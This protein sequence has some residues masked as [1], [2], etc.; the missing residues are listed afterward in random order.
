M[1]HRLV[2]TSTMTEFASKNV[3]QWW[4]TT[5]Q[6]IHGKWIPKGSMLMGPLVSKY[7]RTICSK[8][9]VHVSAPVHLTRRT[10]IVVNVFHVMA[11]VPR[12]VR[13]WKLFTL[14]TSTLSRSVPSLRDR[15]PSLILPSKGSKKYIRTLLLVLVIQECIRIGWKCSQPSS[16]SLALFQSKPH[17]RT[18]G[19]FPTSE[20][21]KRSAVVNWLNTLP[22]FTS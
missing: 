19:T 7:V 4:S 11:R 1:Y 21:W 3:H 17:I 5:L 22:L 9:M 10:I 6:P 16:R 13:E 15:W 20:T 18:S 14:E 2:A 12:I 8:I